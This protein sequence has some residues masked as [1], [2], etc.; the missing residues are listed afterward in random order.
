MAETS[1]GRTKYVWLVQQLNELIRQNVYQADACLPSEREICDMY[2]VSRITVRRALAEMEKAG[3]IYRVQGKG[4]FVRKEKFSARLPSLTSLTEDMQELNISCQSQILALDTIPASAKVANMLDLEENTPVL[5]LKRLRMAGGKP[6]AIETCYLPPSVATVVRENIGDNVS[7]YAIF[8]EKC[9][10]SPVSAEQS[11]EIGLLQPWEQT[12]LGEGTP[13]YT[14]LTTRRAFD[15]NRVPLEYVE[16]KYRGDRYTYH[17][18][19]TSGQAHGWSQ[20]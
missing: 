13:V 9:G 16:G 6:L 5:M 4:A 10:V 15:E 8:R 19:M 1:D 14:M 11:L 12:L 3:T 18:N 17:I 2:G 20:T 7:L